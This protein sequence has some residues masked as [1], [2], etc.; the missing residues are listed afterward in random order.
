[1]NNEVEAYVGELQE[2]RAL[3]KKQKRI[4]PL[5][6]IFAGFIAYSRVYL[7]VHYPIDIICGA[8]AGIFIGFLVYS[9]VNKRAST[10]LPNY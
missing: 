9:L 8:L 2:L 5:L 10:Y 3:V 4:M 1:M 6:F 7:G